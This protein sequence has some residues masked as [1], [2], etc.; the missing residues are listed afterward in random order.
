MNGNDQIWNEPEAGVA[1]QQ[2]S[3]TNTQGAEGLAAESLLKRLL[4]MMFPDQRK[5]QRI[6]GP[7]LVGYLGRARASRPYG[8][9]DVSLGGLFLVTQEGWLPGTEMPI[10]LQRTNLAPDAD[11]DCFTVQATVV[12]WADEGV[13]F[14]IL[15]DEQ[16]SVALQGNPLHARWAS[17]EEM[18]LFLNRLKPPKELA[19]ALPSEKNA[20][21]AEPSLRA[22][23]TS[24]HPVL[25]HS[26]GD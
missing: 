23:F 21:V 19:T 16:E 1:T 13:G 8:V 3:S 18:Q 11:E 6:T 4:R 14:S 7:D 22:A 25:T 9:S 10:T 5:Q 20:N 12:R 17:R 26:G 24:T 2:C 15:L